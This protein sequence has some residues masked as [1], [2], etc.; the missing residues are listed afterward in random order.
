MRARHASAFAIMR[1]LRSAAPL[2]LLLALAQCSN[3]LPPY[4][5]VPPPLTLPE[6]RAV[7]ASGGDNRVA[8]CYNALTTTASRVLAI[9]SASCGPGTVPHALGRDFQLSN[10]PLLQ[11]AR[12]T[13]ACVKS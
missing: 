8:V 9:A 6:Q 12:A 5:T 11:P 13:F 10:C 4:E 1:S 7:T 2:L 3:F